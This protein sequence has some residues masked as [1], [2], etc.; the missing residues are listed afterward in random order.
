MRI[1]GAEFRD[2]AEEVEDDDARGS[3]IFSP[4][5]D[6]CSESSEC[7][8]NLIPVLGIRILYLLY[9]TTMRRRE[10]LSEESRE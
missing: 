10:T 1:R 9:F 3:L 4:P 5:R 6:V 2:N 7:S 8:D